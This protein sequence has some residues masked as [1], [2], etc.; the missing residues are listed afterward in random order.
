M[1][2]TAGW[3]EGVKKPTEARSFLAAGSSPNLDQRVSG[4]PCQRVSAACARAPTFPIDDLWRDDALHGL[5][6][7][8]A[9]HRPDHQD[10]QQ[11]AQDLGAVV[12]KAVADVRAP[13][14]R[15]RRKDGHAEPRDIAEHVRRVG[16]DGHTAGQRARTR[17][18]VVTQAW[19][20]G[21]CDKRETSGSRAEWMPRWQPDVTIPAAHQQLVWIP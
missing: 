15:P 16:H 13:R 11:R 4:R 20:H 9:R 17:W 2:Q 6:Y 19:A 12:A 21:C 7:E 5:P 14:D 3:C 10:A 1:A 8:R 18:C